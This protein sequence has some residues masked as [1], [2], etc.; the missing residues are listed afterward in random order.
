MLL[1]ATDMYKINVY[2]F[3]YKFQQKNLPLRLC[4]LDIK[5]NHEMSNYVLR[6]NE[7]LYVPRVDHEYAKQ[8]IRYNVP[9]LVNQLPQCIKQK[10]STHSLKGF[11]LYV[12]NHIIDQYE[13]LC[14]VGNC[15]ICNRSN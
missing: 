4:L 9:S 8:S 13:S 12:K 6:N 3:Y 14:L 2:K 10:Y 5:F 7:E 1:K 11:V 15:Y